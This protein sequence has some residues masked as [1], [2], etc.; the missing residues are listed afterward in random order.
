MP[1]GG[2]LRSKPNKKTKM[3]ILKAETSSGGGRRILV[4]GLPPKGTFLATCIEIEEQMQVERKKFESTETEIVDLIIF[5]FGFRTKDAQ[6]RIVRSKPMKISGHEKSALMKFIST[7]LGE[8]PKSGFDTAELFGKGA[9]LTIAHAESL[10]G[11]TYANIS[12]ISPIMEGLEGNLPKVESF[13]G[14]LA[15]AGDNAVSQSD[16]EVPF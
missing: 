10:N 13:K 5:Y 3:A 14:L 12:S 4:E 11:K 9:Q 16:D 8:K 1:E 2:D 15:P 7:W 6:L